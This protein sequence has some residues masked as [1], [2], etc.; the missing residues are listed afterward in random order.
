M[1]AAITVAD[2]DQDSATVKG[3]YE[4]ALHVLRQLREQYGRKRPRD[5]MVFLR[6]LKVTLS[7]PASRTPFSHA[8]AVDMR[9]DTDSD[10][11]RDSRS[12]AIGRVGADA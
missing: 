12:P 7:R 10:S 5:A 6:F 1:P 11:P 3:Q 8:P 9:A 4:T 2:I